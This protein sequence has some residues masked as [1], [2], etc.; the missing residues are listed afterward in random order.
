M[1]GATRWQSPLISGWQLSGILR[2]TVPLGVYFLLLFLREERFVEATAW[3]AFVA[4]GCLA[5]WKV[6]FRAG[7]IPLWFF[8]V[9]LA[10]PAA[11][12]RWWTLRAAI[13]LPV[14]LLIPMSSDYIERLLVSLV[15]QSLERI[16]GPRRGGHC[17]LEPQD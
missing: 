12:M 4:L 17:V 13:A 14:A 1:E 16:P 7:L 8:A 3:L 11:S 2:F 10:T 9:Y 15:P 6:Q 5:L